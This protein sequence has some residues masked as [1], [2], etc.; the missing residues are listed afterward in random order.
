MDAWWAVAL[1]WC[2]FWAWYFVCN[3]R[4]RE[5]RL[6]LLELMRGREDWQVLL[7][8]FETVGYSRHLCSLVLFRSPWRLYSARIQSLLTPTPQKIRESV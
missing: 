2:S 5:D 3:F 8:S 4:T 6:R 7:S 1:V